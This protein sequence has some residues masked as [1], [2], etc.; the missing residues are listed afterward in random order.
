MYSFISRIG[1]WAVNHFRS[2]RSKPQPAGNLTAKSDVPS[3]A[4][5]ATEHR[6]LLTL[7]GAPRLLVVA[8]IG[9][10]TELSER[11]VGPRLNRLITQ[12]LIRR[13]RGIAKGV[14][15]TELGCRVVDGLARE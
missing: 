15:L 5:D 12:G 3:F 1:C 9:S 11:T 2:P 8:E 14:E 7:R 13:P 6:I 4:L 10:R